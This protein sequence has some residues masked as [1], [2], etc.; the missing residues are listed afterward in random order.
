MEHQET[1]GEI[2]EKF[3]WK[4]ENF[5]RLNAKEL[6]SD[7]FILGGYPWR[8]LLFPK[9][10]DVD[11][12]L[13]IYFEAMQ[14]ANMSKGWSRDVKFKLLV[15]NQLDTNITVIRETNHELNASQNNW[16]F[17]SFMNLAQ[18]HDPNKGFMVNDACIVGAEVLV[19]NV[20]HENQVNQEAK[21]TVSQTS[22]EKNMDF[23]SV[24]Q[25]EEIY[26]HNPSLIK[27]HPK[28]S[29]EFTEPAFAA[30]GKVIH[31]LKTRKVKDMNDQACKDLQVLWDE[32]EKFKFDLTWLEPHVQHALGMTK[33]VEK[34]LEVKRLK[35]NVVE[36][37][38]ETERLK[39]KLLAAETNL[40][41]ERCLLKGKGFKEMDLDSELAC[42]SWRP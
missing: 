21:L 35:N 15:F 4:I 26:S 25:L 38:L 39:A 34:A 41:I 16:G 7:P 31:F 20:T 29:H 10:N 13:S 23:N 37:V 3:T 32:L 12:S 19:C 28:R 40:D 42:G 36:L 18:L 33:Y 27:S 9:G 5:S 22:V 1:K 14:T 17:H 11:S 24:R 2:S 6:Y 30:L 8:I